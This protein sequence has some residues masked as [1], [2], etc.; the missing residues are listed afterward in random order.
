MS[1][2]TILGCLE[3]SSWGVQGL[4]LFVFLDVKSF[5]PPSSPLGIFL[6]RPTQSLTQGGGEHSIRTYRVRRGMNG[7]RGELKGFGK[8]ITGR[9]DNTQRG[10]V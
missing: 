2:V 9:G 1:A 10:R 4:N 8:E 7:V 6:R 3:G 5:C